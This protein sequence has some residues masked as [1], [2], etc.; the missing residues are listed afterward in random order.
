MSER[1]KQEHQTRARF[2]SGWRVAAGAVA[3][4]ATLIFVDATVASTN[5]PRRSSDHRKRS[6]CVVRGKKSHHRRQTRCR[7]HKTKPA[8]RQ[9]TTSGT[10]SQ[11][12]TQ[13]QSA[14]QPG[15]IGPGP[16][17]SGALPCPKQ[18]LHTTPEIVSGENKIEGGVYVDGGPALTCSP[19]T[20]PVASTIIVT[21]V[22]GE[23]V[24]TQT[25]KDGQDYSIAVPPGE[26]VVETSCYSGGSVTVTVPP[27]K[28]VLLDFV[29]QIS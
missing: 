16:S 19:S 14:T 17:S 15:A 18:T 10:T 5:A 27:E 13:S 6:E 9:T 11:P 25:V 7:D 1:V 20:S 29:C 2:H 28:Q 26:Y 8:Q 21:S 23:P 22:R 3:V 12:N 4:I 24:T